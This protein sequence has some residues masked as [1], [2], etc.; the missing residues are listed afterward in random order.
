MSVYKYQAISKDGVRVNGVVEGFNEVDAMERIKESC[1]VIIKITQ[2]KESNAKLGNILDMEIGGSKLNIKELTMI[3]SQFSILL[4]SGINIIHAVELAGKQATDKKLKSM[5]ENVKKD[6]EGG[7][8]LAASF[9]EHGRKILPV[10]FIETIRAGEQSGNLDLAFKSMYTYFQKQSDTSGKV[11]SALSY[12]MFVLTVAVVVVIVLMAK[13]VPTFT[14]I[15][16]SFGAELPLVTRILIAISD[17]FQKSWIILIIGILVIMVS[18]KAYGAT[19]KGKTML[20][21]IGLNLPVLGRI[22]QMNSASQFANNMATLISAGLPLNLAIEITAKV[23]ENHYVSIQVGKMMEGIESGRS[24]GSMM[25]ESKALPDMLNDMVSVGEETGE[26]EETLVTV[27]EYYDK[28][29]DNAIAAALSKLEPT[30][31]IAIAGIAGFIV[32]AIYLAMFEMYG[33][34]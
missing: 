25:E 21:K 11:K 27:G 24:L 9:E 7:R 20:A 28:E 14:K 5:L 33:V 15:F 6:V 32:V 34:M 29:L 17:F 26:L 16:D 4:R 8:G 10:I 23:I 22:Q 18:Y 31:L 1:E 3:C 13:V 30:L 2:V 19:E 12:P